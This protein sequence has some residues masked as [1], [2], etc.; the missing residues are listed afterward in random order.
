LAAIHGYRYCPAPYCGPWRPI[1]GCCNPCGGG[2]CGGCGDANCA[3]CGG[4]A[5]HGADIYYD[6]AAPA[7]TTTTPKGE[8]IP[9]AESTSILDENWDMPKAKPVPGKPIHNAQQPPR[10]QVGHRPMPPAPNTYRTVPVY[11]RTTVGAG[12]RQANYDQ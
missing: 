6:G 5:A 10:N 2:A 1:F 8:V 3:S 7:K 4:G 11:N 9:P 12:V